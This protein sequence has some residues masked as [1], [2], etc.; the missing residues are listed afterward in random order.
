ML[1]DDL[2]WHAAFR[3]RNLQS[4]GRGAELGRGRSQHRSQDQDADRENLVKPLNGL[5]HSK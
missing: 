2:G 5:S 3:Q 1:E 4:I